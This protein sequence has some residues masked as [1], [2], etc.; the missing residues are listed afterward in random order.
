MRKKLYFPLRSCYFLQSFL[1]AVLLLYSFIS[2]AQTTSY[3]KMSYHKIPT[4]IL[5]GVTERDYTIYLPKSYATQLDRRYPV[6]YLLHGGAGGAFSD[7]MER[8]RLEGFANEIIDSGNACEMIIVC[9]DG[10]Y[11]DNAMWFNMEGW[12]AEDH[13]FRELIPYV[14]STYRTLNDKKHRAVAGLS[15][16]GGGSLFYAISH[17]D[18]F[19]AVYAVSSYVEPLDRISAPRPD[20]SQTEVEK[21]NIIHLFDS[22]TPEQV[23]KWNKLNWFIDCGDDDF[24]YDSNIRMIAAMR[25]QQIPY[26]LR[27]RDG[28]HTWQYWMTSLYLML[29]FVSQSFVTEEK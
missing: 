25:K 26:Q 14:D 8:A 1:M 4:S 13:F 19:S 22:A 24:T 27:I 17:P 21:N 2:Y 18:M 5:P 6:L 16:G 3:G 28:G 7:W 10:R 23:A 29:P 11:R 20:W 9:P 15:M 12:P